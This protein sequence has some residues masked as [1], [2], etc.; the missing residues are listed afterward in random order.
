MP[1]GEFDLIYA[2]PPWPYTNK[3]DTDGRVE[4]KYHLMTLEQIENLELPT[5]NNCV[6]YLWATAPHAKSAF[7]IMKSWGFEYKTQAVWDKKH[8]MGIGYWL[9]NE[10][11]LLYIGTK[12]DYSHPDPDK[13]HGSIFREKKRGHSQKPQV[14][15]SYLE[16]AHPDARKLELFSRDGRVG[17][18]MWGNETADTPQDKLENYQ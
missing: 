17:W 9:G 3:A 15:R 10:H 6:L 8:P 14:V 2:D 5:A 7:D 4:A 12:G 16:K 13:K 11:E 18:T 1:D